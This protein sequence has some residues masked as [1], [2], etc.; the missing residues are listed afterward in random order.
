M[1]VSLFLSF[2]LLLLIFGVIGEILIKYYPWWLSDEA[3]P[4]AASALLISVLTVPA[5]TA[6]LVRDVILRRLLIAA[7]RVRIDK[8]RCK[9]CKYILIGQRERDGAVVC[10]ECGA[11][12]LLS[13]LGLVAADLVP[14]ESVEDELGRAMDEQL[15]V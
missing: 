9:Q 4:Y 2:I 1:S 3:F 6:L 5:L 8:V 11:A 12:L 15:G 13:E 14:P 10:P 7:I